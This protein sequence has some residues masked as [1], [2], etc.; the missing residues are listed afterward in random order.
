MPEETSVDNGKDSGKVW[1]G[2]KQDPRSH[3]YIVYITESSERLFDDI[4]SAVDYMVEAESNSNIEKTAGSPEFSGVERG[5]GNLTGVKQVQITRKIRQDKNT[6]KWK[7]SERVRTD[8]IEDTKDDAKH[9]YKNIDT[10]KL[11]AD[12]IKPIEELKEEEKKEKEQEKE[13]GFE[14]KEEPIEDKESSYKEYD[15]EPICSCKHCGASI[16]PPSSYSMDAWLNK[17]VPADAYCP[18]CGYGLMD[19]CKL[20]EQSLDKLLEGYNE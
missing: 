1:K 6:G 17:Q 18:C 20:N 9:A 16:Y 13:Q 10:E 2:I 7:V 5:Q 11:D 4:D 8:L 3:K 14:N 15:F 12:E 19:I